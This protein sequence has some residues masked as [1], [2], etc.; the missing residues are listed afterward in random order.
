MAVLNKLSAKAVEVICKQKKVGKHADGGGLYLH[1]TEAGGQYWRYK[2]RVGGKEQLSS[3]GTYPEV[4]LAA[5]REK[6][7]AARAVVDVGDSPVEAKRTAKAAKVVEA[8]ANRPFR[9]IAGE[10]MDELIAPHNGHRTVYRYQRNMGLLIAAFGS[11][12][13]SDIRLP[14]LA[15]VLL[16]YQ[17]AGKFET[18]RRIQQTALGIMGMAANRGYVDQNPFIGVT[19]GSGYTSPDAVRKSRPALTERGEFGRLLGDIERAPDLQRRAL[20][21]LA[22]TMVRPGELAQAEWKNIDWKN[23]KMVV[24]FEVLKMRTERKGKAGNG[25]DLEVPLARQTI[26][27]LQALFKLTGGGRYL[28][29]AQS[30]KNKDKYLSE[31]SINSA[32]NRLDYQDIHCAHGFRSSASTMLN[33][34][35][36]VIAGEEMLRWPEQKA[37]IELQLD[38]ND[39]SVQA[40]YDRGGRWKE[41][42]ELMQL[43]ADRVDEMRGARLRLV[44]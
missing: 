27:E 38:H 14:H 28:F 8:A 23:A 12:R 24:P 40:I 42:C 10:W 34:E 9:E 22:L 31:A 21:L 41:R 32:L 17:R 6:H 18:R 35:R 29:P 4:S 43:W 37:L 3:F 44:A 20:R 30:S 7:L 16:R 26:V 33:E 2:F 19:Y 39:A 1:I 11:T 25:R 15:S 5:A 13:I 36:R